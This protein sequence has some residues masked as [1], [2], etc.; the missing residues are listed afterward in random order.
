MQENAGL[1]FVGEE[2]FFS[3]KDEKV[4]LI[5]ITVFVDFERSCYLTVRGY[6]ITRGLRM[7]E[8]LSSLSS[9]A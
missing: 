1:A 6:R 3:C 2:V 4:V 9:P 7:I 8:G 5:G